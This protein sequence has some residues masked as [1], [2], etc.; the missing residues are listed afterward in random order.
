MLRFQTTLSL[1]TT[2]M[3]A[4][5][6]PS[7]AQTASAPE[8]PAAQALA[9]MEPGLWQVN[10]RPEMLGGQMMVLPRNT[11]ICVTSED[12][13]AGRIPVVSMPACQVQEGGAWEGNKLTL[14][15]ACRGLPEQA[16]HRGTIQAQGTSFQGQVEVI[17]A[18]DK[19]GMERGHM[20]YHQ[21]GTRVAAQCPAPKAPVASQPRP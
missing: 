10:T 16:Q 18:P 14:K 13:Q 19:E 7:H 15:L 21:M 17:L 1:L 6:V 9:P 8:A 3:L 5:A 12:V 2:L 20:V 11:R 4:V